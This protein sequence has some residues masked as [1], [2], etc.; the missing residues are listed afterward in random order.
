MKNRKMRRC[1]VGFAFLA[2]ITFAAIVTAVPAKA[3]PVTLKLASFQP[4]TSKTH[5]QFVA[6]TQLIEKETAG[7]VK[8]VLFPGSTL[9]KPRDTYNSVV[10][11]LADLGWTLSGYSKGRFTVSEVIALP[12]GF[13][14]SMHASQVMYD[15]YDKYEAIREEYKDVHLLWLSPGNMRQIHSSVP[16]R[17]PE[18]LKGLK[19]RVPGSEADYVLGLSA[20][21]VSIGGPEVYEALER[22]VLDADFHPWEAVVTYRW[23]EIIRYHTQADLYGGGLFIFA[24]NKNVWNKLPADVQQVFDKYSGRYGSFEVSAKGMWDNWDSH[25]KDFIKSNTQ[26][27]VIEWSAEDKERAQKMMGDKVEPKWLKAAAAKK[28]PAQ[29]ILNDCKQLLKKYMNK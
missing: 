19:V 29:E 3:E 6:W 28:A 13:E 21:P 27:E 12:L 24:M 18:D 2:A 15:L 10:N 9:S 26:N 16:I 20:V 14:N 5:E 25:Y 11:G 23:Y 4:S 7:K 1:T 8:F 22:G 17:T